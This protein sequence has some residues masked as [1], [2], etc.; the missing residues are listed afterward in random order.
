YFP[1][2]VITTQHVKNIETLDKAQNEQVQRLYLREEDS[3][4]PDVSAGETGIAAEAT[5]NESER[6]A[7][8]RERSGNKRSK[9]KARLREPHVPRSAAKKARKKSA[10]KAD[11]SEQQEEA[12]SNVENSVIDVNPPN[13]GEAMLSQHKDQWVKAMDE[14]L[15]GL[16]VTVF[17]RWCDCLVW[18]MCSY[19][20]GVQD[21]DRRGR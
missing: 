2:V 3:D 6:V 12:P 13:L 9:K 18:R 17:G 20:V 11:E 5:G 15:S 7:T 1:R 4:D 14:E 16:R 19:Q 21:E 10:V 8:S